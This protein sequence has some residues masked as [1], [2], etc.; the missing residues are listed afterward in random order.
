M[1]KLT[2]AQRSENMRRIKSKNTKPELTVRRAIR[3]LGFG[4]YRLHRRDIPG[5]PDIAWIGKKSAVF[6]HGCFWHGHDCKEGLRV[7][8]SRADYWVPKIARTRQRDEAHRASLEARGWDTLVLWECEAAKP[9]TLE[10]KLA[11]FLKRALRR[12]KEE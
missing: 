9:S 5:N 3:A 4:G 11:E 12:E 6:V 1:D 7:P 2:P 8:K 10:S